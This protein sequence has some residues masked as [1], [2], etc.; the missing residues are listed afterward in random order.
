[1]HFRLE[2]GSI[3]SVIMNNFCLPLS[4]RNWKFCFVFCFLFYAFCFLFF[5]FVFV[6]VFFVFEIHDNLVTSIWIKVRASFYE[7]LSAW[8]IWF[9]SLRSQES[10]VSNGFQI[11]V[12]TKEIWLT[13]T[14][15]HKRNV[16]LGLSLGQLL[17]CYLGL[18][19][20]LLLGSIFGI[21]LGG[22]L[23]QVLFDFKKNLPK[24]LIIRSLRA[25][26]TLFIYFHIC[27][28]YV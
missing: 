14:T 1:M 6:F 17:F 12:K 22:G 27:F 5:C 28:I 21:I 7:F 20:G 26:R 19:L 15:L 23:W 24:L 18:I 9:W 11:G 2:I 16:V 8:Y 13:K 4:T 3:M 10:N 25:M